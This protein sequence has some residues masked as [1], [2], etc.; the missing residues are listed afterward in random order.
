M[1]TCSVNARPVPTEHFASKPADT[2]ALQDPASPIRRRALLQTYKASPVT[3]EQS[4]TQPSGQHSAPRNDHHASA[5][6][7]SGN[8][9]PETEPSGSRPVARLLKHT[10]PMLSDSSAMQSGGGASQAV[11][12]LGAV[13]ASAGNGAAVA[14]LNWDFDKSDDDDGSDSG[15]S[16]PG[17]P[18]FSQ[19]WAQMDTAGR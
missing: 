12:M 19:Q 2:Q 15:V 11:S 6:T 10:A 17:T 5:E 9:L 3:S 13:K 18:D 4:S 14:S 16:P 8:S 7:D 1:Y